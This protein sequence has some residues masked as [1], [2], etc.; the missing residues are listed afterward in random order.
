MNFNEEEEA[1]ICTKLESQIEL[2]KKVLQNKQIIFEKISSE[3][4]RMLG[5]FERLSKLGESKRSEL[6]EAEQAV[7]TYKL[8]SLKFVYK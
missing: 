7:S 5:V 8:L 3:I 4:L 1:I 6:V 2:L